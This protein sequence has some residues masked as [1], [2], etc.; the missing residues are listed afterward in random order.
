M[1]VLNN[2]NC[3]YTPATK[4]KFYNIA[5]TSNNIKYNDKP[6]VTDSLNVYIKMP[7]T[8]YCNKLILL[9]VLSISCLSG[10]YT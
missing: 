9:Y 3:T 6:T 10:C 4:V 5:K 8:L 7:K 1:S 2:K